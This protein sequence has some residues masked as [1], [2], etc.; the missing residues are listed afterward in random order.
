MTNDNAGV[1]EM[2]MKNKLINN[3]KLQSLFN[4]VQPYEETHAPLISMKAGRSSDQ[5]HSIYP[6]ERKIPM[7]A[8]ITSD[9]SFKKAQSGELSFSYMRFMSMLHS[10][11]VNSDHKNKSSTR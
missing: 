10:D 8:T 2:K 3:W 4:L 7:T 9:N 1:L 11:Y 5:S 6:E